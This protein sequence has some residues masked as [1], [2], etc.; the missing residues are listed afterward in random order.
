[1]SSSLIRHRRVVDLGPAT[2]RILRLSQRLDTTYAPLVEGHID[3]LNGWITA[4]A[5]STP[6]QEVKALATR[7]IYSQVGRS[8]TKVRRG[9]PSVP[10]PLLTHCQDRARC[11]A[12]HRYKGHQN[13]CDRRAH[14]LFFRESPT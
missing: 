12:N 6:T 5:P 14:D 8:T 4:W 9:K 10:Y 7:G 1:V 11:D 2:G 3:E 13:H